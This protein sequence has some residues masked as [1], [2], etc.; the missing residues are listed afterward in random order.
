MKR[1][2]LND[3]HRTHG[4]DAV[5]ALTDRAKPYRR[6]AEPEQQ[7]DPRPEPPTVDSLDTFGGMSNAEPDVGGDGHHPQQ[8]D[9]QAN[10]PP[11]EPSR[12]KATPF[13][14]RDPKTIPPREWLYG[15]HLIRGFASATYAAGGLGKTGLTIVDK[16]ALAT[17]RP[18]LGIKVRQRSRVWIWNGEDPHE[19]LE[20]RI[21]AACIHYNIAR[22][23]LEGW[24]FVDSGRDQKLCIAEQDS[25]T[26]ARIIAPVV[27]AIIDTAL[28][29]KFDVISIDP[30]ISCHRV[31][32]NDNGAIDMVAKQWSDIAN[33]TNA[34]V[35]LVHHTKK[36]GGADATV[37]DGRG[38]SALSNATRAGRVLNRMSSADGEKA[39]VTNHR[40]YFNVSADAKANMSGPAESNDWYRIV[41]VNLGNATAMYPKGDS[42][43]VVTAWKWPDAMA[44]VTGADFDKVAA[45]IRAGKWRENPQ[46]SKWV[47]KAVAEALDLNADNKADKA[48]IVGMLKVWRA[49]GS[50][51]VVDAQDEKREIR[52]F[53]EVKE[54]A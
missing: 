32:E 50:L 51:V 28:G 37:E 8:S 18:L 9:T 1:M 40:E 17:G 7:Q 43:G 54:D 23:D 16:L 33:K 52:K 49:A 29:N 30:F 26:G 41:P 31:P 2:D 35:D 14:W 22:Q 6:A 36:T 48:K 13:V 10:D 21:H 38:A 3:I 53:I 24:L 4:I 11:A 5:R 42:V 34:A 44:G 25:K 45:V 12:L 46:A 39:G 47:G 20:R 27:S 19:E 15:T